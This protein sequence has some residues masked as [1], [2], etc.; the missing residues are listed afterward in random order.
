MEMF[1]ELEGNL[2][3]AIGVQLFNLLTRRNR[4][5]STEAVAQS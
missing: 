1:Q 3:K 5:G 2:I 4:R